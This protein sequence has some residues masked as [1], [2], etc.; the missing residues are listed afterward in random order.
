[1]T[2]PEHRGLSGCDLHTGLG[3]FVLAD[4]SPSLDGSEIDEARRLNRASEWH[5]LDRK[6][7]WVEAQW[8]VEMCAYMVGRQEHAAFT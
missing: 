7:L 6:A 3:E 1:M 4:G 8:S 5:L 2:C